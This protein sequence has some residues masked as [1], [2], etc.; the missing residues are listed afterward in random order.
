MKQ[1]SDCEDRAVES[2]VEARLRSAVV[3]QAADSLAWGGRTESERG[4]CREHYNGG[5][6]N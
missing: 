4:K 3:R 6:I 1:A 5:G 2:R